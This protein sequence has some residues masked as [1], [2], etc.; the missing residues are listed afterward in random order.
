[1]PLSNVPAL[2]GANWQVVSL[3]MLIG[4]GV[5]LPRALRSGRPRWRAATQTARGERRSSVLLMALVSA[6]LAGWSLLAQIRAL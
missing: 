3:S 5:V 4:P 1:M 2:I 6:A